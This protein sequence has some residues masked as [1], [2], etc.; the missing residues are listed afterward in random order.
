MCVTSDLAKLLGT[1]IYLGQKKVNRRLLHILGYKADPQNLATGPNALIIHLPAKVKM[2]ETNNLNTKGCSNLLDDMVQAALPKPKGEL[3][4]SLGINLSERALVYTSGIYTVIQAH[5]ADAVYDALNR[6]PANKRPNISREL[7][8]YYNQN[9]NGWT[10]Q[11]CCF[12]NK[13]VA[14]AEP[15]MW[16]YEPM[17]Y[18]TFILPGVDSHDGGVPNYRYQVE[19]DTYLIFGSDEFSRNIGHKVWYSDRKIPS[20]TQLF[21]PEKVI[22]THIKGSTPN[23]DYILPT[24]NLLQGDTSALMIR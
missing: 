6:V 1:K 7:L 15:L 9:Y 24:N 16:W 12:D 5:S 17:D 10:L 23:G 11:L 8:Q 4:R 14:K 18:S 2:T 3:K 20:Q 19:R 13:D 21:L 22:V